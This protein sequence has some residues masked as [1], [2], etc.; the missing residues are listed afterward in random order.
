MLNLVFP[1]RYLLT[2]KDQDISSHQNWIA[3]KRVIGCD[4][5]G[6]FVFVAMCPLQQSH[7]GKLGENPVEFEDLWHITLYP[8]GRFIGI[9]PHREIIHRR[10]QCVLAKCLSIFRSGQRVVVCY[11]GEEFILLLQLDHRLHRSEIVSDME[12]A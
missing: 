2:V 10:I 5:F 11:K 1:D 12:F 6:D 3:E 8:E 7:R 4:P 9:K